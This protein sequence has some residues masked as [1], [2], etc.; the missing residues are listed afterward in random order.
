MKNHFVGNLD[1]DT[2]EDSVRSLFGRF[3]AVNGVKIARNR[4][5]GRSRGFARVEM[6]NDSEA[7]R[8]ISD[9]TGYIL[10]G[11]PLSVAETT[12]N[13]DGR[14]GEET[15]SVV[16]RG[17]KALL[18]ALEVSGEEAGTLRPARPEDLERAE[19]A[20]LPRE[21]LDLYRDY[22]PDGYVELSQRLWC[23]VHAVLENQDAV[24]GIGLFPHGYVVFASTLDGDAYCIDT[25]LTN[26]RGEH[27]VVLFG[28][29][30]I[31]EDTELSYIQASRV[32]VA[33]SLDEFLV[34]F[35][36]GTLSEDVVYPR[37]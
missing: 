34:K 17:V 3:G 5:T 13:R 18:T 35:A 16:P 29:E 19:K 36:A 22:E 8:A 33:S 30:A 23:A 26:E 20:G 14:R 21:L 27:P 1:F 25:N 6:E 7:D 2:T 37:K 12:P 32:E 4:E 10:D 9:L 15:S 11:R 31:N 24:P 28:H